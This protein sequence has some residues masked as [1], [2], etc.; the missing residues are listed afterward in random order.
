MSDHKLE[1]AKCKSRKLLGTPLQLIFP[2]PRVGIDTVLQ[3]TGTEANNDEMV[4]GR[5]DNYVL[6]CGVNSLP[7]YILLSTTAAG[8]KNGVHLLQALFLCVYF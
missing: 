4:N 3:P 2:S 5:Q 1:L 6:Q 8:E 7:S